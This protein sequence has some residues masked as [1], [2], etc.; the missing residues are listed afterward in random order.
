ML[1]SGSVIEYFIIDVVLD[2]VDGK[3]CISKLPGRNRRSISQNG[4]LDI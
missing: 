4:L 2:I 1:S 3:I